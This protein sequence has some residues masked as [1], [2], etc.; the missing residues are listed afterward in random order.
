M[1]K[2]HRLIAMSAIL[3]MAALI[4]GCYT[5]VGHSPMEP[6]SEFASEI[7]K[8]VTEEEIIVEGPIYRYYGDY[9][10]RPYSYYW[11]YYDSYYSP[12]YRYSYRDYWYSPW[13]QYYDG[14]YYRDYDYKD[15]P[16]R[17]PETRQRGASGPRRT[18]MPERK[19]RSSMERDEEREQQNR[20]ETGNRIQK[21][22]RIRRSPTSAGKR[23][24][25]RES[26]EK[27]DE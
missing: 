5:I 9:Y 17:K 26:Q 13:N 14:R 11:N 18:P 16:Q 23:S 4:S 12:W 21:S 20:E 27:D 1:P 22:P 10:S 6:G 25:K 19:N 15:V 24:V 2:I 7:E 8:G 3:A